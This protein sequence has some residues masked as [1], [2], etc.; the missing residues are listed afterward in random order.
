MNIKLSV[1]Q[2]HEWAAQ[3]VQPDQ[4][5]DDEWDGLPYFECTGCMATELAWG[6]CDPE[7]LIGANHV[8]LR[9]LKCGWAWSEA[10]R[11]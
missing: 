2:V 8:H 6:D 1:D 7:C 9:C 5:M 11:D 10:G 4:I 3:G